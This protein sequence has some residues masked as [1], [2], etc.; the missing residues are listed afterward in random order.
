MHQFLLFPF[1]LSPFWISRIQKQ[2]ASCSQL[3]SRLCQI[4]LS[5]QIVS[6]LQSSMT[7]LQLHYPYHFHFPCHHHH[8]FREYSLALAP[9]KLHIQVTPKD[10][11][12]CS[13]HIS[14]YQDVLEQLEQLLPRLLHFIIRLLI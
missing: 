9:H 8:S 6:N 2:I 11:A 10:S 14:T 13:S 1:E 7:L 3:A 12:V 4:P 5:T